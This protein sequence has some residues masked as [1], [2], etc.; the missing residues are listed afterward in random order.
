MERLSEQRDMLMQ[1]AQGSEAALDSERQAWNR[2]ARA[3]RTK[4][5]QVSLIMRSGI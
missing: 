2:G 1:K 3:R 5:E 4:E